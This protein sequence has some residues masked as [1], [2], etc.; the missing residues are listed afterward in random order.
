[1]SL[2]KNLETL[3][4]KS[5]IAMQRALREKTS[6][7]EEIDVPNVTQSTSHVPAEQ[8]TEECTL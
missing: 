5:A 3:T 4:K 2:R 8:K 6:K 7:K 1:M